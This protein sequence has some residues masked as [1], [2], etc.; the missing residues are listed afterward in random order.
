MKKN[1]F[2]TRTIQ[3]QHNN[4]SNICLFMVDNNIVWHS[5]KLE[6]VLCDSI[7]Y[8][9]DFYQSYIDLIRRK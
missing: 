8:T 1:Y 5:F 3:I 4:F 9:R 7:Y 2:D 6:N